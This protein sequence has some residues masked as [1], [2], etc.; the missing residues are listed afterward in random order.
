VFDEVRWEAHIDVTEESFG[1]DG[2]ETGF[3]TTATVAHFDVVTFV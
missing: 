2:E 1:F 3:H